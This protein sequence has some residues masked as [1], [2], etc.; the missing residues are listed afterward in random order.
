MPLTS[1][2]TSTSTLDLL[3]FPPSPFPPP[4]APSSLLL[5]LVTARTLNFHHC[6]LFLAPP[7]S[8]SPSPSPCPPPSSFLVPA[9]V[10]RHLPSSSLPSSLIFSFPSLLYP[11]VS[12]D[13]AVGLGAGRCGWQRG[14]LTLLC[15]FFSNI[16]KVDGTSSDTSEFGQTVSLLSRRC[17]CVSCLQT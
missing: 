1:S 16:G 12:A 10:T 5:S 17:F 8:L 4:P 2:T 11:A 14:S 6:C 15:R 3:S 13:A 7:P 9:R